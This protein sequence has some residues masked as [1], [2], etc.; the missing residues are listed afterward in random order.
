MRKQRRLFLCFFGFILLRLLKRVY[1]LLRNNADAVI[2]FEEKSVLERELREMV[3]FTPPSPKTMKLQMGLYK[4]LA[5][6]EFSGWEN[7]PARNPRQPLLFVSNH[8]NLGIEIPLLVYELYKRQNI[9][10]RALGDHTHFN[11]PIW[12]EI[13][14]SFGVVDGTRYPCAALM[15]SG[16]AVLVYP[17]GAREA[18]KR[19]TD[20]KYTLMWKDR[21]GFAKMAVTYGCLII[22]VASVGTEDMLDVMYDIP[23]GWLFGGRDITL[24]AVKPPSPEKLQRIYFHF[25]PPISTAAFGH[26]GENTEYCRIVRDRTKAAIE[27]SL[28]LLQKKQAEDPNRLMVKRLSRKVKGLKV[29]RKL[30]HKE[31]NGDSGKASDTSTEEID[32]KETEPTTTEKQKKEKIR[33]ETTTDPDSATSS[34]SLS[35]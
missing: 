23:A 16:E 25:A 20:E 14:K 10:V 26:D 6:P 7:I 22:P 35:D 2:Q 15:Q 9:F 8:A 1:F 17:G 3:Q 33:P 31:N 32:E 19:T 34:D 30:Y 29:L 27:Q 28:Q 24:P 5:N 21:T 12:G 11:I 18:F 13:L 4:W